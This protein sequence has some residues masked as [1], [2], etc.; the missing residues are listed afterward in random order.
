MFAKL[1]I[2][3]VVIYV[4]WLVVRNRWGE[5]EQ[6]GAPNRGPDAQAR[7]PLIPRDAIRTA[8]Y[9]VVALMVVGSGFYLFQDWE[10]RRQVVDVQ[11]I[12]P[13]TG[14]IQTYQARR[15]DI[16]GRGFTTIDGRY[17]RIADMERLVLDERR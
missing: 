4:A 16:E 12:N 14:A 13:I 15:R 10:H 8:A 2:T 5:G 11:V 17:V 6:G 3:A 1:F 7:P 9:A